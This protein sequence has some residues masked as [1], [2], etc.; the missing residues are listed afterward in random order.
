MPRTPPAPVL[1]GHVQPGTSVPIVKNTQTGP[2]TKRVV[3][4]AK[5]VTVN[6]RTLVTVETSG[7]DDNR[8]YKIKSRNGTLLWSGKSAGAAD[9]WIENASLEKLQS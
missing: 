5:P 6:K 7:P 9:S 4:T 2:L 1:A 8:T 3:S